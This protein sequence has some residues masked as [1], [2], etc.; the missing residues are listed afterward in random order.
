MNEYMADAVSFIK[1]MIV[2]A[3]NLDNQLAKYSLVED[4]LFK[5]S[6][7]IKLFNNLV[8]F[9]DNPVTFIWH[10]SCRTLHWCF[11]ILELNLEI[12]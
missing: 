11:M 1:V 6:T 10:H 8:R 5:N 3:L 12:G 9:F 7:A 4:L 2:D